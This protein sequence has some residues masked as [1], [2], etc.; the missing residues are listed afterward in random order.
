MFAAV[1]G[2]YRQHGT[3]PP[4]LRTGIIGG[5]PVSPALL[6]ELRREFAL[7]DLGIAYGVSPIANA[8]LCS[9]RY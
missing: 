9:A 7:D 5:S 6:R 1:L 3:H 8:Q 2:W 4:P